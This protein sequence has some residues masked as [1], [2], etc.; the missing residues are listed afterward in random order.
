MELY[1]YLPPSRVDVIEGLMIK[2]SRPDDFND[3]FESLPYVAG[4]MSPETADSLYEENIESYFD[5]IK[6]ESVLKYLPKEDLALIPKEAVPLLSSMTMGQAQKML[7]IKDLFKDL[8]LKYPERIEGSIASVFKKKW[9][10]LFGILCLSEKYDNLIMWAHYAQNHEGFVLG[11]NSE[12][13]FFF[14]KRSDYDALRTLKK[15]K[16]K[17][18]RPEITFFNNKMSDSELADYLIENI[19]LTKSNHWASEEEWRIIFSL[20]DADKVVDHDYGKAYL[21]NYPAKIITSIYFGVRI[22]ANLRQDIIKLI[23]DLSNSIKIY[24]AFLDPR[25]YLLDFKPLN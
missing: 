2:F 25:K 9:N 15:V 5:Q 23:K 4:L 18:N 8:I 3:P 17:E 7:D 12:D 10:E 14:Q 22:N 13:P 20:K 21:F 16:Y 11:F 1:K 24:Q 6:N 19:L